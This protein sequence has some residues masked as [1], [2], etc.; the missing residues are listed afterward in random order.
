MTDCQKLIIA[1]DGFSS[2][3]KSSFAKAIAHRMGYVYVDTGAMYRAVTLFGLQHGSF[4][5]ELPDAGKLIS[6]LGQLHIEFR[7][8]PETMENSTWLNGRSVEQEIRSL[9]VSG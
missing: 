3:G 7:I 1:I 2:C 6:L 5:G 8:D 4:H 9:D